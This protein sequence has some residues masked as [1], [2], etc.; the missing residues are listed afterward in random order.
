MQNLLRKTTSYSHLNC[1][2]M[3]AKSADVH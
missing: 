3:E 2:S 1:A